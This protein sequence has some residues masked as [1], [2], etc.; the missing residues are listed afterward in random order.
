MGEFG[1]GEAGVF[2]ETQTFSR[3]GEVGALDGVDEPEVMDAHLEE[4]FEAEEDAGHA[5][6]GREDFDAEDG[7]SDAYLFDGAFVGNDGDVGDTDARGRDACAKL[8]GDSNL[9]FDAEN[10][11]PCAKSDLQGTVFEFSQVP[12]LNMIVDEVAVGMI[13]GV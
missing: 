4:V 6:F 10:E 1:E 7:W 2:D 3:V 11:K 5:V 8:A 12:F 9:P 13:G